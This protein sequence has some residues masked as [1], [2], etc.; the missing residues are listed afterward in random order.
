MQRVSQTSG[1]WCS[2]GSGTY[3]NALVRS[4]FLSS[5]SH[6]GSKTGEKEYTPP[7]WHPSSLSLSPNPEVTEQKK[8]M[9]YIISLG[10][11]GK[12][13]YTIGPERGV[14]TIEP[15]TTKKKKRAASTVAVSTFFFLAR[16]SLKPNVLSAF[17]VTYVTMVFF[18]SSVI[19]LPYISAG[20]WSILLCRCFKLSV[21]YRAMRAAM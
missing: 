4:F 15:Q 11:H 6:W 5:L 7:P 9:V 21:P 20:C 16:A 2:K 10:K 13:V 3:N 17:S 12:S 1:S 8:A 14:Y 18:T 19:I